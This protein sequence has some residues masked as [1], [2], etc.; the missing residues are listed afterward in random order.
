VFHRIQAQTANDAW[1][2]AV[3]LLHPETAQ[4]HANPLGGGSREI[5]HVAI[6]IESPRQRWVFARQPPINPAFA[7]AELV[8]ILRG[9]NDAAFLTH[10][11][12]AL[13]LFA[14]HAP[15]LKPFWMHFKKNEAKLERGLPHAKR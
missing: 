1:Q 13:P 8:W 15:E 14:G 10:W 2:A 9:R 3:A 4:L 11:N 12:S 5:H 7:L 6:S